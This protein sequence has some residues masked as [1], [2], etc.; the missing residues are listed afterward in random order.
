MTDKNNKDM[1]ETFRLCMNVPSALRQRLRLYA[2]RT[3]Q[4]IQEA[5]ARALIEFLDREEE[6]LKKVE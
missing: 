2:A 6:K 3:D 5:G 4:T 1:N